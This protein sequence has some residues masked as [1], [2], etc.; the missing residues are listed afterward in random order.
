MSEPIQRMLFLIDDRVEASARSALEHYSRCLEQGAPDE[1]LMEAEDA[2]WQA[3]LSS[4][5]HRA[6][7]W[8]IFQ[9]WLQQRAVAA[10]LKQAMDSAIMLPRSITLRLMSG[11]S[12][13]QAADFLRWL[14]Q[15]PRWHHA[16]WLTAS[17]TL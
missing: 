7:P 14:Q 1:T 11:A 8:S 17:Q 10:D 4:A 13:P 6:L 2:L 15:E 16:I 3:L 9:A 12:G 5:A